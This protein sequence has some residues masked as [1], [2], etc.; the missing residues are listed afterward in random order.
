MDIGKIKHLHLPDHVRSV[1]VAVNPPPARAS[2][3]MKDAPA[4]TDGSSRVIGHE[5]IFPVHLKVQCDPNGQAVQAD[6]IFDHVVGGFRGESARSKGEQVSGVLMR[7][8]RQFCAAFFEGQ[9]VK[10]GDAGSCHVF[11]FYA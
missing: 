3:A 5:N 2:F 6:H 11:T 7:G 1:V 9:I 10:A 4:T 8:V